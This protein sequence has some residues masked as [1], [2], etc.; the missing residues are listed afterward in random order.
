MTIA[1]PSFG[2]NRQIIN[3][4]MVLNMETKQPEIDASL[5]GVL[6]ALS[7]LKSWDLTD[8]KGKMLPINLNTFDN[9][10]DPDFASMLID[11]LS[12]IEENGFNQLSEDEKKQ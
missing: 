8:E 7:I 1:K 4:A 3:K 2:E 10:L 11:E 9:I 12:K 6:R 5:L